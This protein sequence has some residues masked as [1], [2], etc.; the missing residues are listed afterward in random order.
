MTLI[1][2]LTDA[3][4]T[5]LASLDDDGRALA[6]QPFDDE[7]RTWTYLPGPR[8]GV[9]LH[10]LDREQAQL[11][12]R[13]LAALTPPAAYARATAVMGLE[14]VL[15]RIEG[16]GRMRHRGDYW[17]A[18]HGAPGE[19]RWA[20]RFE[21]H[22]VSVRATVADG[23]VRMTPV[24]L[25]A[26][27]ARVHDHDHLVAAPLA[28]EEDLGFELLHALTEEQRSSA[29]VSDTAPDDITTRDLPRIDAPPTDGVPLAAIDGPARMAA[30]ALLGVYLDRVVDG[31]HRPDPDGATFA[32]MGATEPGTGHYY[33]IA[34]PRL[35]AELDNTQNDANHVHTVLR[36]PQADFGDDILATHHRRAHT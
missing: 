24:F 3:T 25:G 34:A 16:G 33:R 9:A 30:D 19:P 8:A 28:P 21:G 27:P 10:R 35:L 18:V 20:V 17:I 22:H 5:F 12:H 13:L 31:S 1:A 26:N 2:D 7:R 32:W 29:I 15:D 6:L 11:A 14:D 36:D 23:E 4:G